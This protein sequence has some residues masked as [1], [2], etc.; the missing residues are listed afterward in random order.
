L[1]EVKRAIEVKRERERER[2]REIG[3]DLIKLIS[4][5]YY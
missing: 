4:V 2:E 3:R 5:D 1:G